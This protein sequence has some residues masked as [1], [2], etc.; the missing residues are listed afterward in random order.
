M[1]FLRENLFTVLLTTCT[2]ILCLIMFFWSGSISGEIDEKVASRQSISNTI[3]NLS[4]P[5]YSNG[6]TN[7][8]AQATVEGIREAL[9]KVSDENIAWNSRNFTVPELTMLDGSKKP[10]FPFVESIWVRDQ[11][12][13]RFAT[14]CHRQFVALLASMNPVALPT[15]QEIE[16]EAAR[17]NKRIELRKKIESRRDRDTEASTNRNTAAA[18]R[19]P[20]AGQGIAPMPTPP[21]LMQPNAIMGQ[22]PTGKSG[23]YGDEAKKVAVDILRV[24]QA[25]QGLIYVDESPFEMIFAKGL[26]ISKAESDKL[27]KAQLGLWVQS[28]IVAAIND[29]IKTAQ[30]LQNIPNNQRNVTTSPI[31]RLVKITVGNSDSRPRTSTTNQ[32]AYGNAMPPFGGGPQ[33]PP[34]AMP[35]GMSAQY[36]GRGATMRTASSSSKPLEKGESLTQYVDNKVFDVVDYSFTVYMPTRFLPLLQESLLKRNYHVI[37]N[38]QIDPVASQSGDAKGTS[39][40]LYYYGL[41]PLREVKIE[42]QLLLMTGFTR[43][44]WDKTTLKWIREPLMPV[45][46]IKKLDPAALRDEDKQLVDGRLNKPWDPTAPKVETVTPGRGPIAPM[47]Q[48]GQ[49]RVVTPGGR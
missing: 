43:G 16:E 48:G 28:D 19:L 42:G 7:M 11:L 34:G 46:E 12:P 33:M 15:P 9:Q 18:G 4:R 8:A 27:W 47:G 21:N 44:L 39:E 23:S 13:T 1:N 14:Q 26:P 5:P 29:T 6:N 10:A 31:K 41:E 36:A 30:D 35:P 2:L 49:R 37:L 32:P 25:Q 38:T 24:R 40:E 17:Q 22:T 20:T 3:Q 45:E